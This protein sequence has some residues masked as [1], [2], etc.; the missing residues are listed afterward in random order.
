MWDTRLHGVYVAKN[1]QTKAI[2]RAGMLVNA[3]ENMLKMINMK[4]LHNFRKNYN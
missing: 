2:W 1:I 3:N 4:D